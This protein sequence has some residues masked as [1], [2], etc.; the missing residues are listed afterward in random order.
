[1]AKTNFTDGDPSQGILGT[2]VLAAFLNAMFN[3]NGGH[4]HDAVDADGHAGKINLATE[5]EGQL[6]PDMAEVRRY[7]FFNGI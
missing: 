1:M 4:K 5:V 2:I 6:S 3:T 7:A